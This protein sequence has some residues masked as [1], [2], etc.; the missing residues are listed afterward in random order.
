[1]PQAI[2]KNDTRNIKQPTGNTAAIRIPLS[3]IHILST[4]SAVQCLPEQENAR[5]PS[6]VMRRLAP[7]ETLWD[8]AKQYRTDEELIRAV[9]Q[10]E[11]VSY[12]HLDVYKRQLLDQVLFTQ[13]DSGLPVSNIVL[14]GIG[15]PLDNMDNV[16]RLSLIHI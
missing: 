5:R 15:E 4:V 13:L 11:A 16:L 10:L 7:G 2:S 8:A 3:L 1:M 9:N 12:T 6:L 14:M